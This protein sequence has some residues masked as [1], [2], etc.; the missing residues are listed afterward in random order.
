MASTRTFPAHLLAASFLFAAIPLSAA[1][2]YSE[3]IKCGDIVCGTMDINTYEEHKSDTL[4][5]VLIEGLFKPAK[6]REYHYLQSVLQTTQRNWTDGT[7]LPVPYVDTPPGG[8]QGDPFDYLVW[9][10]EGEFPQFY[11]RPSRLLTRADGGKVTY[12]WETWIA[13]VIDTK[14]GADPKK[15]SDDTYKVAL[16]PKGFTWGFTLEKTG[17]GNTKDDYTVTKLAFT[18]LNAPTAAFTNSWTQVYGTKP[19]TDQFNITAGDCKDCKVTPEPA[20]GSSVGVAFTLFAVALSRR[21]V[22]RAA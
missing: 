4:A 17:K 3:S 15:A 14:M 13:C 6:A 22:G 21:M 2:I 10:D 5:G 9:Y 18:W 20:P 12:Q 11:D 7:A 8:Y 19:N 1:P 16:L